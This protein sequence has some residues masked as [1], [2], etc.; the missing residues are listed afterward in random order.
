M[1]KLVDVMKNKLKI[2]DGEIAK[3]KKDR[4]ML[5][6]AEG[7]G[8]NHLVQENQRLEKALE[9]KTIDF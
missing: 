4:E 2:K 3:L 7:M 9:Q 5:M 1:T 8:D 6:S